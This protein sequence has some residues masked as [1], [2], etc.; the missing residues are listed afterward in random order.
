VYAILDDLDTSSRLAFT[1]RFFE[2]MELM[3]VALATGESLASVKRRLARVV[4][5]VNARASRDDA[6]APYV[7]EEARDDV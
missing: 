6:L 1:L 3:E 2:E 4:P 7:K 5:I